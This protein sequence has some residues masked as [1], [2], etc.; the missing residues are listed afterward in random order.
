MALALRLSGPFALLFLSFP[1]SPSLFHLSLTPPL[2]RLHFL[3]FPLSSLSPTTMGTGGASTSPPPRALA[4]VPSR[5]RNLCVLAH[6]DHGKTALTDALIASSGVISTRLAGRVR[7][8]DSR[9]DE[10]QRG[11]TMKSSAI[12]LGHRVRGAP[13]V[14]AGATAGAARRTGGDDKGAAAAAAATEGPLHVINVIDSPGHVDFTGEVDVA[15]RVSDGALLVVDV[16]EGVC[17]QTVAVLRAAL[18]RRVVPL[19]VLN[20]ID[21]L[22]SEL[23]LSPS[24]AYA[25]LARVLEQVNVVMGVQ[26]A[27][28]M[29]KQA[30]QDVDADRKASAASPV[31]GAAADE[32]AA[33]SVTFSPELG[34]VVFASALD[35]WAFRVSHFADIYAAKF[36]MPRDALRATLWGDYYLNP[37]TKRIV[38][39]RR[40][41]A[42]DEAAG[43]RGGG[44]GVVGAA[45]VAAVTLAASPCLY[46][47]SWTTCGPSMTGF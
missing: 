3:F 2:L 31:D 41:Q 29:L 5:I 7:Y 11:I 4:V 47:L 20:K 16:V 35:G 1:N 45:A 46:S 9:E 26:E 30:D 8:L 28:E 37:K 34:N 19:L 17:V 43:G 18:D 39:R 14:A 32:E 6:V 22:H 24:E 21:R 44:G 13:A 12:A 36:G 25:H 38:K 40:M 33:G 10:Q 42:A 27:E 15:L 23:H